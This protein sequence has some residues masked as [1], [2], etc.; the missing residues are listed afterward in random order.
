MEVCA[1]EKEG[2]VKWLDSCFLIYDAVTK[3]SP[4]RL[5]TKEIKWYL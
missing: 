5:H 1:L 4:H 2:C 3:H